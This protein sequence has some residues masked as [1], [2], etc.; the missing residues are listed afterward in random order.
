MQAVGALDVRAS[1]VLV[2]PVGLRKFHPS[3]IVMFPYDLRSGDLVLNP[4]PSDNSRTCRADFVAMDLARNWSV[5]IGVPVELVGSTAY[6]GKESKCKKSR[7][8][9]GNNL[10]KV[11]LQLTAVA[12]HG[13]T[14]QVHHTP[15]TVRY[16]AKEGEMKLPTC[17][18]KVYGSAFL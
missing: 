10:H 2:H 8:M 11:L 18:V 3:T 13:S 7:T 5:N 17:F 1:H 4:S 6:V 16:P 9:M 12:Q 15:S 14:M